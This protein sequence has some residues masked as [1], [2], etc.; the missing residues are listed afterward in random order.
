MGIFKTFWKAKEM[1]RITFFLLCAILFFPFYALEQSEEQDKYVDTERQRTTYQRDRN[2][3]LR[4]RWY[5]APPNSIVIHEELEDESPTHNQVFSRRDA[6]NAWSQSSESKLIERRERTQ[7]NTSKRQKASI[8]YPDPIKFPDIKP[9]KID[10]KPWEINP[11]DI[12]IDP[13]KW[14]A[15]WEFIQK[16]VFL[17]FICFFLFILYRILNKIKAKNTAI[18]APIDLE[19]NPNRVS[20]SKLEQQL[21]D[22]QLNNNYREC[23]RIHYLFVLKALIDVSLI[24][25]QPEKTNRDYLVE[26][27]HKVATDEF[28]KC[29]HI[30]ELVWYGEYQISLQHYQRLQ[31]VF[32]NYTHKLTSTITTTL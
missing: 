31:P 17:F 15:R 12:D 29:I 11:P 2:F 18:H 32:E 7:K 9:P 22:A 4:H 24:N 19:W 25:W 6:M 23:V 1:A 16:L 3:S 8:R 30:F 20:K 13:N 14:K 21:E 5:C 26:M 27:R 28:E 10:L